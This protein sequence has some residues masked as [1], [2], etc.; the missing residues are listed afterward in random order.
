[1]RAKILVL[2]D[3][4]AAGQRQDQA[5]AAIK[6]MLAAAGWS[7]A[8]LDILPDDLDAIFHGNWLRFFREHLPR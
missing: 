8:A 4:T 5:G 6:E 7:V 1:M 2:S 3:S